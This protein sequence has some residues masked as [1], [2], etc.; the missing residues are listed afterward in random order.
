LLGLS[1]F[2]SCGQS[3]GHQN[4]QRS[5]TLQRRSAGDLEK[6]SAITCGKLSITFCDVKGNTWRSAIELFL[7]CS[8]CR[9]RTQKLA[10]PTTEIDGFPVNI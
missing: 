2:F 9:N 4:V 1:D 10:N 8:L 7:R 5:R 3:P 6:A